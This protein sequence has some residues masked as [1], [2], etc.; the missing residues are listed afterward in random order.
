MTTTKFDPWDWLGVHC[1][2]YFCHVDSAIMY[3]LEA[4]RDGD[5]P[6]IFEHVPQTYIEFRQLI[7]TLLCNTDAFAFD[8][9]P[10]QLRFVG[11]ERFKTLDELIEAWDAWYGEHYG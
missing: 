8:G 7:C 5:L 4:L 2:G 10:T 11:D 9:D 6:Y 1:G 3:V